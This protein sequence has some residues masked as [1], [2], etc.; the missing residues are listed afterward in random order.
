MPAV[1]SKMFNLGKNRLRNALP[2]LILTL[3]AATAYIFYLNN[4][5]RNAS[6]HFAEIRSNNTAKYLNEIRLVQGFSKYVREYSK[7]NGF[8]RF[9][10]AAPVFLLGRWA[11]FEAPQRVSDKFTSNLCRRPLLIENGRVTMP[12]A[13]TASPAEFRLDG[14]TLWLKPKVGSQ[15]RIELISAGIYLHHLEIKSFAGKTLAYGYRCT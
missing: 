15:Y 10:T 5:E 6:A 7:L 1:R 11:L 4:Q 8:N 14:T 3:L 13:T 9:K 12:P 2:G